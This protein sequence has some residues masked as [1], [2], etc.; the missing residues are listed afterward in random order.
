MTVLFLLL[1]LCQLAT[2]QENR[3]FIAKNH[4][5]IE[6]YGLI[7]HNGRGKAAILSLRLSL[8]RSAF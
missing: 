5:I 8:N 6:F 4:Q 2:S 1:V 3:D 7:I